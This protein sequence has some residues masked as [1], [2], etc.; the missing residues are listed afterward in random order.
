MSL[1]YEALS[2][3]E[4]E[5]LKSKN[6]AHEN[7]LADKN[8][9]LAVNELH[10]PSAGL[11]K[12]APA[13]SSVALQL[14]AESISSPFTTQRTNAEFKTVEP[15]G[16]TFRRIILP[17]QGES[18]LVFRADRN[19]FAAEQYRLVCRTL[20]QQFRASTS[21]MIT[22]PGRGD[23]KTL[24]ALNLSCCL[25]EQ[26]PTLLLE[27]D[28]HRA[29]VG[30]ALGCAIAAPGVEDALAGRVLPSETVNFIGELSLHVAMV[31]RRSKDSSELIDGAGVSRFLDWA[32]RHFR[33]VVLDAPP[34]LPSANVA[35][36]LPLMAAV[37]VVI[38]G[39]KTSRKLSEEAFKT[40]GKHLHGVIFNEAVD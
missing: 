9:I 34:V 35:D 29:T 2:R 23:G 28:L 39:R 16:G 13:D 26:D 24:T 15:P 37:V 3:A 19:G 7:V 1:L 30:K 18:R 21:L 27:V 12:H 6:V 33:W 11:S 38:R 36:L 17:H 31:G 32:R 20:S 10:T 40:L 22:S 8:S 4:R 25:A 14:G 5:R